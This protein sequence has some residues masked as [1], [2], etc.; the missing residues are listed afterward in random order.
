MTELGDVVTVSLFSLRRRDERFEML[1]K[2]VKHDEVDLRHSG[3]HGQYTSI[4]SF[5]VDRFG[6][7]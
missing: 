7:N 1:E 2:L 5:L 6:A 3:E 4:A